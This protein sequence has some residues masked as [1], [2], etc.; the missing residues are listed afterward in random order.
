[1]TNDK[2]R[3]EIELRDADF[4]TDEHLDDGGRGDDGANDDLIDVPSTEVASGELIALKAELQDQKDRYLRTL[5]DFENY[6][7]RTLKERSDLIKYQG[8]R[9][10]VDLVE[11]VDNLGLALKYKDTEPEK[12]RSGLEMVYRQFVDTLA[13]WEVRAESMVGKEFDPNKS[14]ALSK[15]PAD[16]AKPGTVLSEF[17][18]TYMYKDKLLRPGSVVVA[19]APN[20]SPEEDAGTD[21]VAGLEELVDKDDA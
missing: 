8:E 3:E 2:S 18:T 20:E 19:T 6:K 13:R 4:G 17:K 16:D 7:K 12:L 9:I 11:V 21:E 5:A 10:L 1:M 14:E 15:V